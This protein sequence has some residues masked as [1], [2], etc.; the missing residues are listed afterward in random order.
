M[1]TRL[2]ASSSYQ[3]FVARHCDGVYDIRWQKVLGTP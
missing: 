1:A 3:R 2:L